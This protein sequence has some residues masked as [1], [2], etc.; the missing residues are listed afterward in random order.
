MEDN[1]I[2]FSYTDYCYIDSEGND[3]NQYRKCPKKYHILECYLE[4][5][6]AA[7]LLCIIEKQ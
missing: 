7:L 3:L 4:I 1:K 2:Y 5:Q 6:L